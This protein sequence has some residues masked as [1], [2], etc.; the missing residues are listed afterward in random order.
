MMVMHGPWQAVLW[1]MLAWALG[2]SMVDAAHGAALAIACYAKGHVFC[3]HVRTMHI[4]IEL[5]STGRPSPSCC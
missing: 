4:R 3:S 5:C 1:G 2:C